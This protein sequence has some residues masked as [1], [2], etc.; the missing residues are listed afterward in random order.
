MNSVIAKWSSLDMSSPKRVFKQIQPKLRL[1]RPGLYLSEAVLRFYWVLS[2][3]KGFREIVRPL[4][5]L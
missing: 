3:V 1:F 5:D 4:N 2:P